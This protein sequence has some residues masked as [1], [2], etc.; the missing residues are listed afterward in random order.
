[1]RPPGALPALSYLGAQLAKEC[2][3]GGAQISSVLQ[4]PFSLGEALGEAD[5]ASLRVLLRS[6]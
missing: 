2:Y 3:S 1:M 5:G 4:W 6:G